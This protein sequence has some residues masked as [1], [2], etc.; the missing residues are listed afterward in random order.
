MQSGKIKVA[1]KDGIIVIKLNGYVRLT[2]CTAFDEFIE[3]M[4]SAENF[5]SV[6]IDLSDA[7]GLDS[8]TLGLLA[9]I[10]VRA[11]KQFNFTP[12]IISTDPS[13]TRLLSSMC[14]E[15]IFDIRDQGPQS[16]CD[17][18]DLP[19]AASSEEQ[20]KSRVLEAHK[21][22]MGVSEENAE[23]FRDLVNTLEASPSSKAVSGS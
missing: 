6:A 2:L 4:F 12:I 3:K 22:L 13:V 14:F 10:A 16:L 11:R 1:D 7:E 23:C 18:G 15:R 19:V 17:Y 21:T 20:V 8:T 5:V 9:K